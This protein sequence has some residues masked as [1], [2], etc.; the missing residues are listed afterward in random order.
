MTKKSIEEKITKIKENVSILSILHPKWSV[1]YNY[2]RECYDLCRRIGL[3]IAYCSIGVK[4]IE[5]YIEI[6]NM[7]NDFG[8]DYEE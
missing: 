6:E 3:K 7:L 1:Q 5:R 8:F 4:D 2:D